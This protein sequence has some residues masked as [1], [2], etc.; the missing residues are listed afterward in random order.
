MDALDEHELR[1]AAILGEGG[2]SDWNQPL[3]RYC[4]H[5]Q[6][7][8]K[9]PCDVT[10]SEDFRW[11]EYY[12]FGPGDPE[13]YK[14]L[15]Q[16]KP[17]YKDVFELLRVEDAG[18]SVWAISPEDLTASVRRRSDGKKFSLGLSDLKTVDR[19]SP[20]HQLLKDYAI[21]FVNSR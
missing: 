8:L 14:Q 9:L 21:W 16:G 18:R 1:I 11:E 20:N 15:R 13:E 10:G 5:L 7:S 2:D 12:V 4:A 19:K 17:S 3:E 6:A